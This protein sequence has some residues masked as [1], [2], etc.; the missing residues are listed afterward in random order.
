LFQFSSSFRICHK[1]K[2]FHGL[3]N[4]ELARLNELDTKTPREYARFT[5]ENIINNLIVEA[6]EL[7]DEGY[8]KMITK[9]NKTFHRYVFSSLLL[10]TKRKRKNFYEIIRSGSHCNC[11]MS[12][13]FMN[14]YPKALFQ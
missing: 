8:L 4:T 11:V 13:S 1:I 10:K 12:V 6:S 5:F 9:I 3:Q 14:F 2:F 7:I